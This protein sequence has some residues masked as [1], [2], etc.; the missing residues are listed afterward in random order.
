MPGEPRYETACEQQQ[1][2]GHTDSV[3]C[4]DCG[5][6]V[7]NRAVHDRHHSI[8]SS[9]AWA[10]AVLKTAHLTGHL[11]DR[12]D[13]AER[14]DSRTFDNWSADALAEVAGTPPPAPPVAQHTYTPACDG[15]HGPGPCPIPIRRRTL[16]GP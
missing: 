12:Y 7:M 16:P 14:I 3:I 6:F 13:V 15:L 11:H 8:Q 1:R 2:I 9:W 4:M 5:V 10:L